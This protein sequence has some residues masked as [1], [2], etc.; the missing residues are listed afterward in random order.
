MKEACIAIIV[1]LAT[2]NSN[3]RKIVENDQNHGFY[4]K[5]II[6]YC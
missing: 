4:K 1:V 5:I 3:E 2:N 6:N